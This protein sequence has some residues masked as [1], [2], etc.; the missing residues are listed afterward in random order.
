MGATTTKLYS[1]SRVISVPYFPY[2]ISVV[3]E[4]YKNVSTSSLPLPGLAS[5][6]PN[7]HLLIRDRLILYQTIVPPGADPMQIDTP[8][9]ASIARNQ[10]LPAE[11]SLASAANNALSK[12]NGKL[13][14][15]GASLGISIAQW[16]QSDSM[17][18][19]RFEKLNRIL[20]YSDKDLK[21]V[22]R[23]RKGGKRRPFKLDPNLDRYKVGRNTVRDP[24][25]GQVLEY[26]FGWAPLA[27]DIVRTLST[28]CYY[29]IPDEY[30]RSSS[31]SYFDIEKKYAGSYGSMQTHSWLG[32]GRVTIG[33]NVAIENPNLW[34]ANRA[35]L[36]NLPGIIWDAIP[37]SFMVNQFVN[38]NQLIGQL[39]NEVG[40]T[41]TDRS[42]TNT[43]RMIHV[44][45][46]VKRANPAKPFTTSINRLSYL[47]RERTVGS[48]P[49]VS[50]EFRVPDMNIEKWLILSS[51]AVQRMRSISK[52]LDIIYNLSRK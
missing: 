33:A 41:I 25:A 40:L 21:R 45:Q 51:L 52:S 23:A 42:T 24:L 36:I 9:S 31:T 16:K 50:T 19:S 49:T 34:L 13:H 27:Q 8:Q 5:K 1:K 37:W 3:G 46:N 48:F 15:K 11:F 2:S 29:A 4:D 44:R 14:F 10:A 20:L 12:Y 47:K 32:F 28:V 35:G 26:Y 18:R 38:V 30:I 6:K 17:I 39:S 22:I 7:P 43:S